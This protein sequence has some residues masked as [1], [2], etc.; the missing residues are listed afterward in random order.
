M[1]SSSIPSRCIRTQPSYHHARSSYSGEPTSYCG[2]NTKEGTLRNALENY[3]G[4]LINRRRVPP[5][6]GRGDGRRRLSADLSAMRRRTG[7]TFCFSCEKHTHAAKIDN[8]NKVLYQEQKQALSS[9]TCPPKVLFG[10]S[11]AAAHDAGPMRWGGQPLMPI[12][13]ASISR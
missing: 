4:L 9:E 3:S 11:A 10:T 1:L 12:L 2:V 7:K 5:S 8:A 6:P 13:A